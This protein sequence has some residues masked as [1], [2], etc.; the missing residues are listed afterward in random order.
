MPLT[1][2]VL[3]TLFLK[4]FMRCFLAV[5]IPKEIKD[6][7]MRLVAAARASGVPASFAKPEQMH[8]TLAFF[9]EITEARKDEIARALSTQPLPSAKIKI[10]STGFFGSR[11]YWAGVESEELVSL[12]KKVADLLHYDEGRPFSPH[13]TLARLKEGRGSL[14]PSD[15]FFGE[16]AA[17]ELVLFESVLKPDGA[18]HRAVARFALV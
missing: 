11:V 14:S 1:Q 7:M 4:A 15:E 16:F 3:K 8:L 18:E 5:E 17:R 12:Q 10:A 9:G 13:I 6:K 2:S